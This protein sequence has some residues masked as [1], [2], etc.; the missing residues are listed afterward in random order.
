MKDTIT[1]LS[2]PNSFKGS[3]DAV[4]AA[5]IIAAAFASVSD[6]FVVLQKP[7]ADGG[8][9]FMEVL[10]S[11]LGGKKMSKEVTRPLGGKVE[12]CYGMAGDKAIIEMAKAS[13]LALL[14]TNDL[15]PLKSHSFGT[16]ELIRDAID[17][18]A[19]QI[20]LGIGGSATNDAGTGILQALGYRFFDAEGNAVSPCG[21]HLDRIKKVDDS[22]VQPELKGVGFSIACDVDNPLLGKNGCA[23]V[24]APQKGATP[25][26]VDLLEKKMADFAE[27]MCAHAGKDI[28]SMPKGGAAGG[29]AAGLHTFLNAELKGGIELVMKA[30]DFERAWPQTDVVITT[31]GKFDFQTLD[32]KGPYGI[33]KEAQKQGKTVVALGGSIP[34]ADLDR[35]EAFDALFSI[36]NGPIPLEEAMA[37]ADAL[38][39]NAVQQVAKF[40][41]KT[42]R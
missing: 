38:L 25:K 17:K 14:A 10:T 11:A 34:Q 5:E 23:R 2:A 28:G 22:L 37:K 9:H 1:V 19:R 29:I 36:V 16:G 42:Y 21:G 12:A 24:F 41:L 3:L 32:G 4:A 18:G 40:L 7:I 27:I 33:A 35:F 8:D 31:E 30:L 26:M 6:R 15:N 20:I 39:F 13:G